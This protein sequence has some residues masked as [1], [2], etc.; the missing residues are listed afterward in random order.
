MQAK[1]PV[2]VVTDPN[3]DIGK[4]IEVGQFGWW[5]E[6]NDSGSFKK[7]VNKIITMEYNQLGD[8]A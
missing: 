4:A 7:L 6:S 2:L 8:N 3:T 5:C 1:I